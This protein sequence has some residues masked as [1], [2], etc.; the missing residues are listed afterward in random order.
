[1]KTFGRAAF[2]FAFL[3]VALISIPGH[4]DPAP[5]RPDLK[6]AKPIATCKLHDMSPKRERPEM[7][8]DAVL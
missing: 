6:N 4:A 1:M 2:Y 8:A 5:A 3:T 7:M